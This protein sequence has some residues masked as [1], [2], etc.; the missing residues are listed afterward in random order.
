MSSVHYANDVRPPGLAHIDESAE[1]QQ[2]RRMTRH[3][4]HE[5][6]FD[7]RI[8]RRGT[9]KVL[10]VEL[11]NNLFMKL[12]LIADRELDMHDLKLRVGFTA[13]F[14]ENV[15]VNAVRRAQDQDLMRLVKFHTPEQR[16]EGERT[17]VNYAEFAR[18]TSKY[19]LSIESDDIIEQGI[20]EPIYES[21]RLLFGQLSPLVNI[22]DD[23]L[24][25]QASA[26]IQE[27][28]LKVLQIEQ[29]LL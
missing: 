3:G 21:Q 5:Q 27:N 15:F 28:R 18:L 14:V 26:M 7:A 4:V 9:S 20:Q 6:V 11:L 12:F 25:G 17:I 16:I 2:E 13:N 8:F 19:M 24:K 10:V 23:W 22:L 1:G 29:I